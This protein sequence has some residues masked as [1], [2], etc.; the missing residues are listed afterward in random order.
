VAISPYI[1][2]LRRHVGHDLLMLPSVGAV[3]VDDDAAP[4]W[5]ARPGQTYDWL[6][7]SRP[8]NGP[9]GQG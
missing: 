9:P 1:A 6:P 7:P 8:S 4:A 2:G 5:F 3:V